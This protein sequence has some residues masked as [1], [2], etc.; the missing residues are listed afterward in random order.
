MSAFVQKAA[1]NPTS[2]EPSCL[3]DPLIS[4]LFCLG[5]LVNTKESPF[6]KRKLNHRYRGVK[7]CDS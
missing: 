5:M 3:I 6:G 1:T 7:Q 2:C 4:V